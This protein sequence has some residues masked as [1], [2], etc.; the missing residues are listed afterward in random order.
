MSEFKAIDKPTA[1][2]RHKRSLADWG[3][4]S[5]VFRNL[6][7]GKAL[8]LTLPEKTGRY[9]IYQALE[10]KGCHIGMSVLG[11]GV[12]AVWEKRNGR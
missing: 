9:T 2:S 10:K 8:E 5:E 3:A 1:Y 4:I 6:P 7:E 12:F 11:K